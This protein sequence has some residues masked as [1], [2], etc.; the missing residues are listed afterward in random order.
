MFSKAPLFAAVAVLT[1][2]IGIGATTAIFSVADALLLRPL[3]YRDP[4]RV[5]LI[6]ERNMTLDRPRNVIAPANFLDWRA[7]SNS[8]EQMAAIAEG[9]L[10]VTGAGEPEEVAVQFVS[11]SLFGMLGA[12]PVIGRGFLA[13]EEGPDTERVVILSH[14]YWQSR[15]GGDPTV[16]DRALTLDGERFTIVGVMQ[17][18]FAFFGP[19]SL[20]RAELWSPLQI[21]PNRDYRRTAGR[22]MLGAARLKPGV[23]LAGAQAEMDTIAHRLETAYPDF[24]AN[25]GVTLVPLR[26]QLAGHLRTAL[27]VLLAAVGTVL[28]IACA[29]VA[30][31][32]LARAT[33]R[34]TEIA[35]RTSLGA[36][37]ARVIRQMLTENLLLALTGGGLGLLLAVWGVEA[38]TALGSQG[39]PRLA[40]IRVDL[41]VFAFTAAVSLATGL[42]FGLAPALSAVRRDVNSLLK[43]AGRSRLGSL[44]MRR[45]SAAVVSAQIALSLMLLI[46]AGLLIRSF[47]Q[48]LAVQPGF[49]PEQLLTARVN[50]PRSQY[51]GPQRSAFFREAIERI[52]GLPEVRSASAVSALPF[53]GPAVGTGFRVQGRPEPAAGEGPTTTV[54]SVFPGFFQTMGIR[55]LRGR[56]FDQRATADTPRVYVVSE[57][58][59]RAHFPNQDPLGQRIIVQLFDEIPGEIIGVVAD[60]KDSS[61]DGESGPAV[62]YVHPQLAFNSMTLVLRAAGEPAG[63]DR[64]LTNI[65]HELDS[66]LPVSDVRVMDEVIS[67]TNAERRFQTW[68]LTGFAVLA[69][70]LATI[71]VYGVMSYSVAQ[72]THELGVRMAIGAQR[73]DVLRLVLR[74]GMII[75]GAGLVLGLG[76]AFAVT[77][78]MS[79]LLYNVTPTDP[80][81]FGF[82]ALL[83][84]ATAALAMYV[85]ARRATRVDPMVVLR[86]E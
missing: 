61:L 19:F 14:S 86:Y 83:L 5:V 46:G 53:S 32:L 70:A 44:K 6:W 22:Y 26:E 9:R 66:N 68:L 12:K 31:L 41:R 55:L 62:Y 76:G 38:L 11:P 69:L 7:Q 74:Q 16:L 21:N 24:N 59:A 77:R 39:L 84:A 57:A 65:I 49:E 63:L 47:E 58:L 52:A 13:E 18:S 4:D 42:V 25:W 10:S 36:G 20:G 79:S 80:L 15:F 85:P 29:N 23:D 48:L 75:A 2:A 64:E 40:D 35:I 50:L 8:F 3:S 71:G 73:S 72:R 17:P 28:L 67:R 45:A 33:S 81:T 37:R 30:N 56:E 82:V 51:E 34:Q 1:L 60:I 27:Y 43:E 54:R 78:A